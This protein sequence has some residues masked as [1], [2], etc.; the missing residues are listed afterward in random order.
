MVQDSKL[1]TGNATPS[2]ST[3]EVVDVAIVSTVLAPG[4]TPDSS[5]ANTIK[6]WIMQD[7]GR[8]SIHEVG[9]QRDFFET[10]RRLAGPNRRIGRC[11]IVAHGRQHS[12]DLPSLDFD[13][14]ITASSLDVGNLRRDQDQVRGKREQLAKEIQELKPYLTT[15]KAQSDRVKVADMIRD[16]E[17][18]LKDR[19][20]ELSRLDRQEADILSL[21]DVMSPGGQIFLINCNA[22]NSPSDPGPLMKA[23]GRVM[24]SDRGGS[25]R[26]AD[27]PVH[28]G[29]SAGPA[30]GRDTMNAPLPN[31][32]YL[33]EFAN[34]LRFMK[35]LFD[36]SL[37]AYYYIGLKE[38][39]GSGGG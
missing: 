13:P 19:Q 12:Y 16:K 31:I 10:L 30:E 8:I 27:A 28:V 14:P 6:S 33:T 39:S 22:A 9:T 4:E 1:P 34:F 2:P 38:G 36:G 32:G 24:L 17:A 25:I 7:P 21:R 29:R 5:F 11:I 18:A 3:A 26:G 23:I 20:G 35:G 15:M 37:G